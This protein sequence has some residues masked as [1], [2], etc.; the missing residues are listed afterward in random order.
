MRS[1]SFT[2]C[3]SLPLFLQ[4][5]IKPTDGHEAQSGYEELYV[6]MSADTFDKIDAAISVIELLITSILVS[7]FL[8][9]K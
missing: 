4:D 6:C 1:H 5:E 7:Q 9:R 8:L 2:L 3:V